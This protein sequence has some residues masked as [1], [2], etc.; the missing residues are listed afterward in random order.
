MMTEP[1][2]ELKHEYEDILKNHLKENKS[3]K[4]EKPRHIK[5]ALRGTI[6]Q[7]LTHLK[8]TACFLLVA[9]ILFTS[10]GILTGLS[11]ML[12]NKHPLLGFLPILII[13]ISAY[14]CLIFLEIY[15]KC[16]EKERE[17][18]T[19]DLIKQARER[20]A[21]LDKLLAEEKN[22]EN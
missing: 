22:K 8:K 11:L 18:L 17:A 10:A 15:N 14:V 19:P 2:D 6:L 9:C 7:I 3:T 1:P 21:E 20:H 13:I 12:Y 5:C 4:A 16:I